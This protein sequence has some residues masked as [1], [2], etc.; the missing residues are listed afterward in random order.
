MKKKIITILKQA[1]FSDEFMSYIDENFPARYQKQFHK[2]Y[3]MDYLENP[4]AD[5]PLEE[6]VFE[7]LAQ[8]LDLR[9]FYEKKR[10]ICFIFTRVFTIWA[11][12][13]N[14]TRNS[15]GLTG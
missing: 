11:F 7:S 4:I 3:H 14:V 9:D 13:S 6:N 2:P 1:E 12:A 8:L 5:L 15:M 10:L